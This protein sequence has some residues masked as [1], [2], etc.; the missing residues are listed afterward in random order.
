M[1]EVLRI[2]APEAGSVTG[3]VG[4]DGK[5]VRIGCGVSTNRDDLIGVACAVERYEL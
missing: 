2:D 5:F 1:G 4:E 3:G